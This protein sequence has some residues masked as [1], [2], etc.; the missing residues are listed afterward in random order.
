MSPVVALIAENQ[1]FTPIIDILRALLIGTPSGD[2]AVIAVAWCIG[3]MVVGYL[4]ARTAY[5]RNSNH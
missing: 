3:F 1:P 5:N 4:L 2:R